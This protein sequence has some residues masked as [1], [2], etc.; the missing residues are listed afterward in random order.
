MPKQ[1]SEMMEHLSHVDYPASKQDLVD[2]CEKM[3][4]VPEEDK[5]WF[6]EKLPDQTYNSAE[7]VKTALGI[8]AM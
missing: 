7:E 3:S 1:K 6:T 5:K 4:D 8:Q 2:A